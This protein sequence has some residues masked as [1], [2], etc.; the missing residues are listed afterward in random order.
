MLQLFK[1]EEKED[2]IRSGVRALV[3]CKMQLSMHFQT[4]QLLLA[5]SPRSS[6]AFSTRQAPKFGIL[7]MKD[8]TC[9]TS[10]LGMSYI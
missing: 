4:S 7:C 5:W 3:A 2:T 9:Q 8:H 1:R 10:P 6:P